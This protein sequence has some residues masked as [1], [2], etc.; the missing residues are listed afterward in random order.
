MAIALG[1][2]G[3]SGGNW[4]S[5]QTIS[6]NNDQSFLLLSIA[7]GFEDN[8]GSNPVPSFNGA[9]LTQHG[10]WVANGS[11]CRVGLFYRVNADIGTYNIT[12]ATWSGNKLMVVARSS[13]SGVDGTTPLGTSATATGDGTAPSV[14]VSSAT[15]EVVVDAIVFRDLTSSPT[16]TVGSGQTEIAA[17]ASS[18][19]TSLGARHGFS[20]EAGASSV[21]MSWSISDSR[22]WALLAAAL[23]P[24]LEQYSPAMRPGC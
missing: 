17:N 10:S 3:I 7:C 20:Q 9:A 18:G 13:W 22:D 6:F 19:G 15:G 1:N 21:T 4:D 16:L 23:K 14:N 5:N 24:S 8:T 2:S 11:N 12:F